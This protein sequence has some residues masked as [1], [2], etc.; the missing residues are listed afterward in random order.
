MVRA[1]PQRMG[2]MV[3]MMRGMGVSNEMKTLKTLDRSQFLTKEL[4][5]GFGKII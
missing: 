5:D 3:A 4:P 2:L 1:V